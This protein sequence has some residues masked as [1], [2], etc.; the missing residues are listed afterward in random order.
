MNIPFW[1]ALEPIGSGRDAAL[2]SRWSVSFVSRA[3][4]PAW[5]RV[6]VPEADVSV[7]MVPRV[8]QLVTRRTDG[9]FATRWS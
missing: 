1:L 5:L 9:T 6:D 2:G 4:M 7:G 3:P 8:F